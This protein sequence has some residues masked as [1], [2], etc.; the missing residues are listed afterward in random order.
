MPAST[1]NRGS[2]PVSS[3][4]AVDMNPILPT[5]GCATISLEEGSSTCARAASP[6]HHPTCEPYNT[7]PYTARVTRL[8]RARSSRIVVLDLGRRKRMV[9]DSNVIDRAVK[10]IVCLGRS[11]SDTG[12]SKSQVAGREGHAADQHAIQITGQGGAIPGPNQVMP[13][14]KGI[15]H[16]W[17]T[18]RGGGG[19]DAG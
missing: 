6:D 17:R 11:F 3:R 1:S 9:V 8:R 4:S 7:T 2:K 12:T 19:R 16:T 18:A 14:T 15:A 10:E 13:N 5:S